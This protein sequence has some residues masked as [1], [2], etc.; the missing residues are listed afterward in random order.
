MIKKFGA[1]LIK[2]FYHLLLLSLFL[3]SSCGQSD[4]TLY[5]PQKLKVKESL[6]FK[7]KGSGPTIADGASASEI[8]ITLIDK[9]GNPIIDTIP[10]FSATNSGESNKYGACSS[11]DNNGLSHCR[12]TSTSSEFKVLAIIYP[13]TYVSPDKLEFIPGKENHLFLIKQPPLQANVGEPFISPQIVVRDYYSNN[14]IDSPY[15]LSIEAYQDSACQKQ[16]SGTLQFDKNPVP[17]L[18]DKKYFEYTNLKYNKAHTIF[19]KITDTTEIFPS[20]CSDSIEFTGNLKYHLDLLTMPIANAKVGVQLAVEPQVQIKDQFNISIEESLIPQSAVANLEIYTDSQCSIKALPNNYNIGQKSTP[21]IKGIATDFK[22][23]FLKTGNFFLGLEADAIGS[24]CSTLINVLAGPAAISNSSITATGPIAAN[25]IHV[26]N[27]TIQLKDKFNFPVTGIIPAI[28][29]TDTSST[30]V[31]NSCSVTDENGFSKCSFT[32]KT[33]ETKTLSLTYP[34]QLSGSTILFIGAPVTAN[35][36]ISGTDCEANGSDPSTITIILKD[37]NSNAVK[38]IVPIFN[39]SGSDNIY[40]PCSATNQ[41]GVSSCGLLSTKAEIKDISMSSPLIL[42]G[43]KITFYAGPAYSATSSITGTQKIIANGIDRSDITINLKDAYNN[44]VSGI[45]PSFQATDTN[46]KNQMGACSTTDSNGLSQCQL[47]SIYAEEKSLTITNPV[48]KVG[49]NISFIA[50]PA[51]TI[52]FLLQG[53]NQIAS[54]GLSST[55]FKASLKD[56]N[57]NAC[58]GANITLNIPPDGGITTSNPIVTNNIGDATFNLVSSTKSGHYLYTASFSESLI[59]TPLSIDF[60]VGAASLITLEII[61]NNAIDANGNSATNLKATV[62]DA[63][64]NPVS[65]ESLTLAFSSTAAGS[66]IQN[67]INASNLGISNFDITSSTTPGIYQYSVSNTTGTISNTVSIEFLADNAYLS[68]DNT[69]FNF[70]TPGT[71]VTQD[72]TLKNIGAKAT[73]SITIT[74]TA[75]K[76]GNWRI[77]ADYCSNNILLPAE[78]C[79]IT[80]QFNGSKKTSGP[81]TST[82]DAVSSPGRTST[83]TVTGTGK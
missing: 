17:F 80:Y 12:L 8:E 22:I 78:I 46:L 43:G 42:N 67:P 48:S 76:G 5:N 18:T 1:S 59:S 26:A 57:N 66:T 45:I 58:V 70:G 44:N 39:A 51:K 4:P 56:E 52:L 37:I 34:V 6:N 71:T 35:S 27:V 25:G 29:V 3:F 79:I 54:D 38:G 33:A 64:Y 62:T 73:G 55:E 61:G 9:D 2:E 19:L 16:A 7:I 40:G 47:S 11:S 50:G 49:D 24:I 63:N 69:A 82:I 28:V 81:E 30:N 23:T 72:F 41:A 10:I 77:I 36:S 74:K 13:E 60:Q 68:W 21:F 53:S 20:L 65:N 83:I 75:P 15:L 31:Y 32:S 14:I